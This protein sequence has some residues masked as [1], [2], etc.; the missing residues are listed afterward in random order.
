MFRLVVTVVGVPDDGRSGIVRLMTPDF[1]GYLTELGEIGPV[2]GQVH[3]R[4]GVHH[5]EA[6]LMVEVVAVQWSTRI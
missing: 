6:V 1:V 2:L 5:A 4:L 3:G